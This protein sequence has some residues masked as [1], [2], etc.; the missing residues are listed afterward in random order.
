VPAPPDD[1]LVAEENAPDGRGFACGAGGP[2]SVEAAIYYVVA[3]A[4]TNVTKYARATRATVDVER[5]N[6]IAR[7]VVSDD[8]VGGAEPVLGSGLSG[9]ADRVEALGGRLQIESP[10]GRGT[11]LTGEIPCD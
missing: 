6:G 11:K 3:E 4:V 1:G 8:G 10:P 5:S 9:L 7:V 2:G